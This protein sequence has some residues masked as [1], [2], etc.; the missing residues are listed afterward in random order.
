MNTHCPVCGV[1]FSEEIYDSN[2]FY[3]NPNIEESIAM[4]YQ[5]ANGNDIC[6]WCAENV[7]GGI[8][9]VVLGDIDEYQGYTKDNYKT[10]PLLA[11]RIL[12]VSKH[13]KAPFVTLNSSCPRC[14]ETLKEIYS[15]W[16]QTYIQ[17]CP[18][19]KW[20]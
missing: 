13:K 17:K 18:S 3:I 7:L 11:K 16:A 9:D 2:F 6:L 14:K 12:A 10:E 4:V 8:V 5:L 15:E 1:E 19:C 20:C